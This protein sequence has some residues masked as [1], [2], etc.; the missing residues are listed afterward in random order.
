GV[1]IRRGDFVYCTNP[2][3]PG[4]SGNPFCLQQPSISCHAEARSI[5][6]LWN[7]SFVP[8]DDSTTKRL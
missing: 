3:K 7:R 8:Q 6:R 1:P 5:C 4:S 2:P